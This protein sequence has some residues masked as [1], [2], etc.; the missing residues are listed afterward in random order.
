MRARVR[1]RRA[2]TLQWVC[3][4]VGTVF[5]FWFRFSTQ[6]GRR[7]IVRVM[8]QSR[9]IRLKS[10]SCYLSLQFHQPTNVHIP[11]VMQSIIEPISL[12][13]FSIFFF[14]FFCFTAN[15]IGIASNY[16]QSNRAIDNT[17]RKN[18]CNDS[19]IY[20]RRSLWH[21]QFN[22]NKR[23]KKIEV[24]L[25]NSSG[26]LIPCSFVFFFFGTCDN[27][28]INLSIVFNVN[29]QMTD[30]Y[31]KVSSFASFYLCSIWQS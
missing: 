20:F 28:P 7:K 30:I 18:C 12:L 22:I 2:R 6:V 21:M 31:I 24:M 29:K 10:I 4:F 5:C 25:N 16:S 27:I 17:K 19:R 1:K 9:I 11:A 13:F 15:S 23:R 3:A 26:F 8:F 14:F